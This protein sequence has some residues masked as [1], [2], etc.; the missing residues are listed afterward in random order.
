MDATILKII[1]RYPKKW[2]MIAM[3]H[4][5]MRVKRECDVQQFLENLEE[6]TGLKV[7]SY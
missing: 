1:Q 3:Q 2:Y 7:A 6:Y 4:I 5:G